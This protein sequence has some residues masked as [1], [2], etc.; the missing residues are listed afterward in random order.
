MILH[1]VLFK[2]APEVDDARLEEMIRETESQLSRIDSVLSVRAG[3]NVEPEGEW[4]FFLEVVVASMEAL[5]TYRD[6]PLHVKYVAEII[7][8]YTTER[9]ALDFITA[10]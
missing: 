3:R 9:K 2:L 10:S 6:D 5:A 1:L 7:K 8:P 4:P